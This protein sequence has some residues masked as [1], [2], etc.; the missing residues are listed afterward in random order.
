[1]PATAATHSTINS[2][3]HLVACQRRLVFFAD[4]LAVSSD[5]TVRFQ[6]A[7]ALSSAKPFYY[8]ILT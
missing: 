1:V 5:M 7:R 3:D 6:V 2:N 4:V 8:A